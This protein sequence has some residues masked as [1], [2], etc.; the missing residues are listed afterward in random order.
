MDVRQVIGFDFGLQSMEAVSAFGVCMPRRRVRSGGWVHRAIVQTRSVNYMPQ[1]IACLLPGPRYS[2][3]RTMPPAMMSRTV[4][5]LMA[6]FLR[7]RYLHHRERGT[8]KS[9][10]HPT[11]CQRN[12]AR[13]STSAHRIGPVVPQ[14]S[15]AGRAA[16]RRNCAGAII[17]SY[18]AFLGEPVTCI[19]PAAKE[20][21]AAQAKMT[22][23]QCSMHDARVRHLVQK[24]QAWR[25]R[26][27]C[28]TRE[29]R[30][31]YA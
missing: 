11:S 22:T 16:Q 7:S 24:D 14:S 31:F 23:T 29:G 28:V 8:T 12:K 3:H 17:G 5:R 25:K 27:W 19:L 2:V 18:P 1:N 4:V 30:T 10:G 15:H 20:S 26:G 13:L 9:T 6:M 21:H